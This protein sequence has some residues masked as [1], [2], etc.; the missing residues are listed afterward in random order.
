MNFKGKRTSLLTLFFKFIAK[1][2]DIY[3][4][5]GKEGLNGGGGGT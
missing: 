2:R 5:Y 1:K 4:R 3:D